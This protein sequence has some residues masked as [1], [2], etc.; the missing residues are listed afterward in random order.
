[1]I[2]SALS[3][4]WPVWSNVF[5]QT[6]WDWQLPYACDM[7]R[8]PPRRWSY[9]QSNFVTI[10]SIV[11]D[12]QNCMYCIN[13]SQDWQAHSWLVLVLGMFTSLITY[14]RFPHSNQSIARA[15][16]TARLWLSAVAAN[17][18][19]MRHLDAKS[20]ICICIYSYFFHFCSMMEKWFRSNNVAAINMPFLIQIIHRYNE[21]VP[22]RS[23]LYSFAPVTMASGH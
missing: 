13:L 17:Q 1:M 3:W 14:M 23:H 15:T 4:E 11:T 19:A 2:W 18:F 20:D 8:L 10:S 21:R 5:L 12:C 7:L 16:L 22:F 9:S 6:I